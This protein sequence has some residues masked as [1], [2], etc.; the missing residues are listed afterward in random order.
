MASPIAHT[1]VLYVFML[2]LSHCVENILIGII[3]CLN[4]DIKNTAPSLY[5]NEGSQNLEV[6]FD[7]RHPSCYYDYALKW[8][9]LKQHP[10]S[11]N[12]KELLGNS[13][14]NA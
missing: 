2:S 9:V 3:S 4:A 6:S 1:P 13:K 10:N 7:S 11:Y 14:S 8:S 5:Y 12:C